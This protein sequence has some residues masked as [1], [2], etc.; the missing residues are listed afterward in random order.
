MRN[1]Q[2]AFKASL[3]TTASFP[4][5]RTGPD[6]YFLEQNPWAANP[7]HPTHHPQRQQMH[8]QVSDLSGLSRAATPSTTP[9]GQRRFVDLTEPQ[10]SASTIAEAQS[11]LISSMAP[12]PIPGEAARVTQSG[13]NSA[14]SPGHVDSTPSRNANG[15][16]MEAKP[17]LALLDPLIAA[18]NQ[19]AMAHSSW[20][21]QNPSSSIPRNVSVERKTPGALPKPLQFTD[22]SSSTPG[23]RTSTPVR[24]PVIKAEDHSVVSRKSPIPHEFHIATPLSTIANGQR[25]P[26]AT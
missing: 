1:H 22:G 16:Q 6:Q 24:Y 18:A 10:G 23:M 8:R 13:Q 3:S 7:Q 11:R 2:P 12:T 9:A 17:S 19:T 15:T 14:M 26:F 4:R 25:N 20:S 5:R 21:E